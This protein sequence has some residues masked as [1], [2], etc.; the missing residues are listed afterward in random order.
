MNDA[1]CFRAHS[2]SKSHL[3][4]RLGSRRLIVVKQITQPRI[5]L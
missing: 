4:F 2:G 5:K 3:E 1:T